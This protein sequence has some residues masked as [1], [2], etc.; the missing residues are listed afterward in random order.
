MS[1]FIANVNFRLT[2]HIKLVS[3]E[4]IDICPI[5]GSKSIIFGVYAQISGARDVAWELEGAR[6]A[7]NSLV[8]IIENL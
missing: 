3:F 8:Q 7:G 4:N 6:D 2:F 1:Y 5:Y